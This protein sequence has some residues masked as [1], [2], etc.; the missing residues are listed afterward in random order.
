[1]NLGAITRWSTLQVHGKSPIFVHGAR[2]LRGRLRTGPGATSATTRVEVPDALICSLDMEKLPADSP[3][4]GTNEQGATITL[5]RFPL[6]CSCRSKATLVSIAIHYTINR[7]PCKVVKGF[8]DCYKQ[9]TLHIRDPFLGNLG[10]L[11]V[12]LNPN[13]VPVL[14]NTGNPCRT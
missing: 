13:K 12:D 8:L 14:Q 4:R 5:D 7:L 1:M 3:D 6:S 11:L 10:I 9:R 2:E